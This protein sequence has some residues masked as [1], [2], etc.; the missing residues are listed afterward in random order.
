LEALSIR[1]GGTAAAALHLGACVRAFAGDC[2]APR[3]RR[4]ASARVC[5]GAG[6]RA[7]PARVR[8]LSAWLS[9]TGILVFLGHLLSPP[10]LQMSSLIGPMCSAQN[11]QLTMGCTLFQQVECAAHKTAFLECPGD[12]KNPIGFDG[13]PACQVAMLDLTPSSKPAQRVS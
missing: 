12:K 6:L 8:M 7:E 9:R 5:H 13:S 4:L 1:R 2:A 3:R 10:I 11:L